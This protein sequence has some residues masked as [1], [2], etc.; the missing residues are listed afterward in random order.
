MWWNFVTRT[1]NPDLIAAALRSSTY[2]GFAPHC[3]CGPTRM[4]A[5]PA[6]L[7][8]AP[9]D[10]TNDAEVK[11]WTDHLEKMGRSVEPSDDDAIII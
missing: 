9:P 7:V 1:P 10:P 3:R 8:P 11:E 4:R 6:S 5:T 2:A